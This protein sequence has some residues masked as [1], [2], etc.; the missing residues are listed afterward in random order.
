MKCIPDA[1]ADEV[2]PGIID[3]TSEFHLG[4]LRLL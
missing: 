2:M 1:L 4:N 3:M